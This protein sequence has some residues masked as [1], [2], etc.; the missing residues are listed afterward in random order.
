MTP[1]LRQNVIFPYIS[2]KLDLS[3]PGNCTCEIPYHGKSADMFTIHIITNMKI[4]IRISDTFIENKIV[5][6][7]VNMTLINSG[8]KC[9][10]FQTYL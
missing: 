5:L 7:C 10:A 4:V 9:C 2:I 6:Y 8:L 3:R 1:N